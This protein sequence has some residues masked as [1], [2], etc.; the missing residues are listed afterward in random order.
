MKNLLIAILFFTNFILLSCNKPDSYGKLQYM[1]ID[2]AAFVM[3]YNTQFINFYT[4]DNPYSPPILP[5]YEGDRI[6]INNYGLYEID[7]KHDIRIQYAF[8]DSNDFI[9]DKINTISILSGS[10]IKVKKEQINASFLEDLQTIYIESNEGDSIPKT[11]LSNIAAIKPDVGL[12]LKFENYENNS[13][14]KLKWLLTHFRPNFLSTALSDST[15]LLLQQQDQ[16]EFLIIDNNILKLNKPLPTLPKLKHLIINIS[17]SDSLKM[18]INFLQQNPQIESLTLSINDADDL[19]ILEPLH[20]LK[21]LHIFLNQKFQNLDQLAYHKNLNRLLI[22]QKHVQD[23]SVIKNLKHL[24]WLRLPD[25]INQKEIQEIFNYRSD[26]EVLE[27]NSPSLIKDLSFLK[28]DKKLKALTIFSK[29]TLTFHGLEQLKQ[30]EFLSLPKNNFKDSTLYEQL[31]KSLPNTK[32]VPNTGICLSSIWILLIIPF[33][34]IIYIMRKK[35]YT[36]EVE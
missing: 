22:D 26:V 33:V 34:S 7:N 6:Q 11:Y 14:E 25:S 13:G 30:L 1:Q 10:D 2:S 29:D 8:K 18:P 3:N 27:I 19:K 36:L 15:I 21:S 35:L 20:S 31:K 4:A 9:N 32:M 24:K 28:T 17:V 23:L 5:A 12:N 16:I